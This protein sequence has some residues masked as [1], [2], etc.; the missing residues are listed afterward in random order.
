MIRKAKAVWRGTGK[1]GDGD[2]TTDSGVLS[3]TPY[4]FKTRFEKIDLWQ[5]HLLKLFPDA[6]GTISGLAALLKGLAKG[7]EDVTVNLVVTKGTLSLSMMPLARI[8]PI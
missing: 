5:Q 6:E 1:E 8:P 2:L 3:E 7:G 4:S